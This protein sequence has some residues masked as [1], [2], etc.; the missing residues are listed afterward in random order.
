MGIFTVVQI[1]LIILKAFDLIDW[2]WAMVAIPT[3][4]SVLLGMLTISIAV[5]HNMYRQ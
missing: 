3:Y 2:S 1:V 4:I 5:L